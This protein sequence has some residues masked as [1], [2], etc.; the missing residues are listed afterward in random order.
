MGQTLKIATWNVNSIRTRLTHLYDWIRAASPDVVC[1]QE[2]KVQDH[3]FPTEPFEELGYTLT[4]AGQKSYNGVAIFSVEEPEAVQ[5]GLPG[6]GPDAQKRFLAATIAGVRVLCAYIPNGGESPEDPKFAYK[7]E[8][9]TRLEQ[10]LND[11]YRPENKLILCGDYNIAPSDLDVFAPNNYR[12]TVMFHSRE[13][14]FL[15]RWQEWGL[16]DVVRHLHPDEPD[17]YT[18][19]NY[20]TNAFPQNRGWRIDHLW[21]TRSLTETCTQTIIYRDERA[22]DKPSDHAPVM[23]IFNF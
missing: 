22:K 5:I 1:L 3:E 21:A 2:T 15:Q 6:D 4:F 10:H 23:A 13:H 12:E 7:M 16:I 8:F 11:A 17:L 14:A 20:R 18:W 19:W 9:L